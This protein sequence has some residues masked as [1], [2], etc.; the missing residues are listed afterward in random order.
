[1]QLQAAQS[2]LVIHLG[3]DERR[4]GPGDSPS[5]TSDFPSGLTFFANATQLQ[6]M[7]YAVGNDLH[8]VRSRF[9]N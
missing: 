2:A 3:L 5:P 6:T 7:A 9:V 4:Q 8:D 1:M